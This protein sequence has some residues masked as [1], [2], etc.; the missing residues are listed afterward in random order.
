LKS[1]YAEAHCNLGAA[2]QELGRLDEAEASL[3][4]AI[5][6][7]PDFA[8]PHNNLGVVLQELG[9]LENAEESY[10]QAIVLKADYAEAHNGF[11]RLLMIMGQ[12]R[13]GINEEIIGSGII[14]FNLKNGFSIRQEVSSEKNNFIETTFEP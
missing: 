8:E 5:S 9:R 7:K 4:Q 2:L 11:A 6:L 3:R 12:Y 14:S 1:D 13:E 10:R